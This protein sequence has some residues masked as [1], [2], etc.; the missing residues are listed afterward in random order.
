MPKADSTR[1]AR[2]A[3][4]QAQQPERAQPARRAANP[5]GKVTTVPKPNPR[6]A[7]SRRQKKQLMNM[8]EMW[9]SYVPPDHEYRFEDLNTPEFQAAT[10]RLGQAWAGTLPP[11]VAP[12]TYSSVYSYHPD[13][14]RIPVGTAIP[15]GQPS[16]SFN[17]SLQHML[18][19]EEMVNHALKAEFGDV[20]RGHEFMRV[21]TESSDHIGGTPD[22]NDPSIRDIPIPGQTYHMR[23][24]TGYMDRS[25]MVCWMLIDDK[26]GQ[27]RDRPAKLKIYDVSEMLPMAL[28]SIEDGWR[29]DKRKGRKNPGETFCASDGSEIEFVVN[30]VPVL[31]IKLPERPCPPAIRKYREHRI[32]PL[33]ADRVGYDA[34][35]LEPNLD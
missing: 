21:M 7:Q 22:P 8:E 35:E 25:Q 23:L 9:T 12:P 32:L 30:K 15:P 26:T 34:E 16:T 2:Q 28:C 6:Q 31:R 11:D 5:M 1:V 19:S 27:P 33:K 20:E 18:W 10:K 17:H 24:W 3:R 4:Q 13:H 29:L 14:R